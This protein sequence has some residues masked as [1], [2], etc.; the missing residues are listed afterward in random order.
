MNHHY[1]AVWIAIAL[2]AGALIGTAAALL[3]FAGGVPLPL[4][5]VAGGA[6]VGGTVVLVL[7]LVRYAT[8]ST[9]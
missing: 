6:A 2:L 8:D 9:P 3:S 5:I 7:A 1:R 4:A